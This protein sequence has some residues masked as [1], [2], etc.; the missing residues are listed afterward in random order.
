[1]GF[2]DNN[3]ISVQ[4]IINSSMRRTNNKSLWGIE[5]YK[6]PDT[7]LITLRPKTTKFINFKQP[8][9]IEQITKAKEFIPGPHYDVIQNWK[10]ILK[11]K[12]KFTKSPRTTFTE[13]IIQETKLRGTPAPGV[14]NHQSFI[15]MLK[16]EKNKSDKTDKLCAFIEE[17]KYR[18]ASTPAHKY[19]VSYVSYSYLKRFRKY[20][21]QT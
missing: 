5:G 15:G 12:G 13:S 2:I 4:E 19:D 3:P 11:D 17:A 7:S 6:L 9:Y 1:M 21:M 16:G 20:W 8:H 10:E 14:Y 18:G